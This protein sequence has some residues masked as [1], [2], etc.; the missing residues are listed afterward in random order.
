MKIERIEFK[1]AIA[2]GN[3][4]AEVIN[5]IIELHLQPKPKLLPVFLWKYLIKHLLK[6]K[7]NT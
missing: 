7:I 4:R 6:L 5:E 1:A 2:L 3:K